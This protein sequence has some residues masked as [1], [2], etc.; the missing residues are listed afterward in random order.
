MRRKKVLQVQGFHWHPSKTNL[1]LPSQRKLFK[2]I[3]ILLCVSTLS[4]LA[5]QELICTGL[6]LA[7]ITSVKIMP[8][9][10]AGTDSYKNLYY[11]AV[12][13]WKYLLALFTLLDQNIKN[14]IIAKANQ[15]LLS[16]IFLH[17]KCTLTSQVSHPMNMF[18]EVDKE[19][20]NCLPGTTP[21]MRA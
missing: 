17:S 6:F 8:A 1:A 2:R 4:T 19:L 21:S 10:Y 14:R 7:N 11:L 3:S 5:S 15:F 20:S 13:L 16:M 18:Q 12:S 9:K